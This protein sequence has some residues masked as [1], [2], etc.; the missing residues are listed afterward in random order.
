MSFG[1]SDN[2]EERLKIL[3]PDLGPPY[4][5][6]QEE[7]I[8]LYAI[9]LEYRKLY[10]HSA[11]RVALLNRVAGFFFGVTQRALLERVVLHLAC[12]TDHPESVGKPNLTIQRF[13]KLISD[14]AFAVSVQSLVDIAITTTSFARDMRN[15]KLAHIDLDLALDNVAKPLSQASRQNVED[16]LQSIANVLNSI[17]L[18]YF[19]G[20]MAYNAFKAGYDDGNALI[21]S[22]ES[23]A[24]NKNCHD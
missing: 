2:R 4:L 24:N 3:G 14:S 23:Y 19:N 13:P 21:Y 8:W 9:W 17:E 20:E 1:T 12:L 6:L 11:E 5:A 7:L 10:G 15:R 16:S 18:H 22:L